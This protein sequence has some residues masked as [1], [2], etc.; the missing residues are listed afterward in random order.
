MT[1]DTTQNGTQGDTGVNPGPTLNPTS[2][3]N[4]RYGPKSTS[5]PVTK[6]TSK[7]VPDQRSLTVDIDVADNRISELAKTHGQ[8][9]SDIVALAEI[10]VPPVHLADW[11]VTP[12]GAEW[13]N[14][15]RPSR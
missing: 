12:T 6:S 2:N 11:F 1:T 15:W 14:K 3:P 8:R 7:S 4:P 13:V 10:L 5:R 9:I